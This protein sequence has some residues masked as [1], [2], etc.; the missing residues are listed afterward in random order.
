MLSLFIISF[1]LPNTSWNGY[2][3]NLGLAEENRKVKNNRAMNRSLF[4]YACSITL[5]VG[6]PSLVWQLHKVIRNQGAT[7]LS[8]LQLQASIVSWSKIVAGAPA[9]FSGLIFNQYV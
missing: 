2:Q 5:E 7:S 3:L 4:Y 1:R 9:T 6:S 8:T